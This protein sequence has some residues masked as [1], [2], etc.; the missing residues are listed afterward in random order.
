MESGCRA[1]S[2]GSCLCAVKSGRVRYIE[3]PGNPLVSG[4]CYTCIAVP[5]GDLELEA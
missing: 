3:E 1:G 4:S 5:D 2:C